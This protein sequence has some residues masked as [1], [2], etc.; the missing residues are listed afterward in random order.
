VSDVS[1]K[2]SVAYDRVCVCDRF[3]LLDF[4]ALYKYVGGSVAEWLA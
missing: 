1:V 2:A 3:Y 4:I